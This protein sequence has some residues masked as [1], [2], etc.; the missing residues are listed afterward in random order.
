MIVVSRKYL[1]VCMCVSLAQRS[2]LR[3]K[4]KR[5]CIELKMYP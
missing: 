1:T 2:V 5:T 3:D 4:T